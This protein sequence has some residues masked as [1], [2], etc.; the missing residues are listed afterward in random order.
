LTA[1][2]GTN[3]ESSHD[4]I[5]PAVRQLLQPRLRPDRVR[6]RELEAIVMRNGGLYPKD[7]W[8][9][10]SLLAVWT[11]GSAAAYT[12][13]L[14]QYY[15]R[16]PIRDHGL[17]ASEGRMTIPLSDGSAAGVLDIQSHYFEFIPV[18]EANSARPMILEAH[19]LERDQSYFILLTTSSGL[20]R[21]NIYDVVRC[22]GHVGTT[23]RLEF[24]NKGMNIS[25]L[26][27]EK[28][29]ESQVVSSLREATADLKLQLSFYTVAPAWG[30]PPG[31]CLMVE[32][33][34]LRAPHFAD[35]LAAAADLALQRHNREYGDKR[36]TGR[37]KAL[38]PVLLPE[39]TWQRF[40]SQRQARLGGSVEQY[41]HPCLTPD[42]QFAPNLLREFVVPA[43]S[44]A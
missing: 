12:A 14:S 1:P 17:S 16:V 28:I 5:P 42:L 6:A 13:G 25:S 38:T 37:L 2:A 40:A 35:R 9:D 44:A 31:Y 33:S 24:L 3:G 34:D 32:R 22:T 30:D 26:T 21:Y 8:S 15:G 10:A 18:S 41:K 27:G 20:Y 36:Q 19:E 11:G 4:A 23:P 43:E 39:G 29:S 7:Y